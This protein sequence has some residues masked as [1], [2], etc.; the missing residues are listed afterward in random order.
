M[1]FLLVK[2]KDEIFYKYGPVGSLPKDIHWEDKNDVSKNTDAL[3][4]FEAWK[5][6]N[7][8]IPWVDGH[9]RELNET[10]FMGNRGR[11]CTASF[12]I[13]D[14]KIDWRLGAEY[15][16]EKLIDHDVASNWC[17]WCSAAGIISKKMRINGFNMDK[18][19]RE[20]DPLG[21]HALKWI[22]EIQHYKPEIIHDQG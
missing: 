18:Q 7:T 5:S 3:Y 22:P 12:L 21:K 8:G 13:F 2:Y 19:A 6:G 16:Q 9:M 10:G 17:S 4:K 11:Q 20:Y 14:L 15:F 1:R